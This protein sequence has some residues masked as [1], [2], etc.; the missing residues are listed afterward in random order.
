MDGK[1]M[2]RSP[3]PCMGPPTMD[4]PWVRLRTLCKHLGHPDLLETEQVEELKDRGDGGE[5]TAP[6]QLE[7]SPDMAGGMGGEEGVASTSQEHEKDGKGIESEELLERVGSTLKK[8]SG[9]EE[10]Q[11]E[12]PKPEEEGE[13]RQKVEQQGLWESEEES[14]GQWKENEISDSEEDEDT[15]ASPS[16]KKIGDDSAFVDME[17]DDEEVHQ[18]VVQEKPLWE[19]Q[20]YLSR[21]G[22]WGRRT[23]EVVE[24]L[25]GLGGEQ[26]S[27]LTAGL[28]LQLLHNH[29]PQIDHALIRFLWRVLRIHHGWF[30]NNL[31]DIYR[32]YLESSVGR[33]RDNLAAVPEA[34]WCFLLRLRPGGNLHQPKHQLPPCAPQ[35]FPRMACRLQGLSQQEMPCHGCHRLGY[36]PVCSCLQVFYCGEE[37][38]AEDVSHTRDC[39]RQEVQAK[40]GAMLLSPSLVSHR[41]RANRYQG[42]VQSLLKRREEMMAKMMLVR[43]ETEV[44]QVLLR[45]R[46]SQVRAL[47]KE[48]L[49]LHRRSLVPASVARYKGR[50]RKQGKQSSLVSL[51]VAEGEQVFRLTKTSYRHL[52]LFEGARVQPKL[53]PGVAA[54]PEHRAAVTA[55]EMV[56]WIADIWKRNPS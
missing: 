16:F 55:L 33:Y 23:E 3:A 31:R 46:E 56:S 10:E 50:G 15:A 35:P 27:I 40:S 43:K 54:A 30:N 41:L 1:P 4:T 25:E 44:L 2:G 19:R 51:E 21:A 47:Q 8:E 9:V 14:M 17:E 5:D 22:L 26:G 12:Q 53:P 7:R 32:K 6:S 18:Q 52:N 49:D 34:P 24:W 37:C 29:R 38:R 48:R 42:M 28:M 39:E 13:T 20:E 45:K 36:L 11:K